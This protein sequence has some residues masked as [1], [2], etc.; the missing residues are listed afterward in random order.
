MS[1]AAD[2]K[3]APRLTAAL[4]PPLPPHP[5]SSSAPPGV[6][7][8]ELYYCFC[9]VHHCFNHYLCSQLDCT[10]WWCQEVKNPLGGA[11]LAL[12]V[13]WCFGV[14]CR[15]VI[16]CVFRYRGGPVRREKENIFSSAKVNRSQELSTF[17]CLFK[18]KQGSGRRET[19]LP[20]SPGD[21]ETETSFG[22]GRR[23]SAER[24][25][26]RGRRGLTG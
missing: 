10:L 26:T 25:E 11:L 1:S 13:L 12:V 16:R 22:R 4:P 6:E 18:N 3:L 7:F 20:V 15:G 14:R 2:R 17:G 19:C 24:R 9:S 21:G 23:V 5:P 8:R